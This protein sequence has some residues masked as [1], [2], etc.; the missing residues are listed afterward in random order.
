MIQLKLM[1]VDTLEMLIGCPIG[2]NEIDAFNR[3]QILDD[4]QLTRF[5]YSFM[6]SLSALVYMVSWLSSMS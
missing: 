6:Y 3:F 2:C 1:Q 4:V 5:T